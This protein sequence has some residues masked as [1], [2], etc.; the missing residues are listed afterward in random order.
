MDMTRTPRVVSGGETTPFCTLRQ[1]HRLHAG[2][3]PERRTIDISIHETDARPI[4]SQRRCK[5]HR[6]SAL[7]NPSLS[8]HDCNDIANVAETFRKPVSLH[9]HLARH[10]GTPVGCYIVPG[11]HPRTPLRIL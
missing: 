11:F 1:A 2:H 10:I 7:S 5:I 6:H 9:R 3:P 8:T 4:A